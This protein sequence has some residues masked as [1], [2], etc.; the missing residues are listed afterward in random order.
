[1]ASIYVE[2]FYDLQTQRLGLAAFSQTKGPVT[3]L[4]F[5][6]T[7]VILGDW[8]RLNA[9]FTNAGINQITIDTT[10]YDLGSDGLVS[11]TAVAS[12]DWTYANAD[13]ATLNNA[14]AAF[15]GLADGGFSRLDNFEVDGPVS[16]VPEPSTWAML[17]IGLFGLGWLAYRRKSRTVLAAV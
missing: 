17:L 9:T 11:P 10:L 3:S 7:P 15:S 4:A 13:I 14:Y 5:S 16:G 1:M 2:G 6:E 12:G 8:Y